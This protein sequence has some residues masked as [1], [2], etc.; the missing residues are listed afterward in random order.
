MARDQKG[1]KRHEEMNQ[2]S[3]DHN[4]KRSQEYKQK[5]GKPV[6]WKIVNGKHVFDGYEK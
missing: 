4:I 2:Q 6:K 1:K 3:I 5:G